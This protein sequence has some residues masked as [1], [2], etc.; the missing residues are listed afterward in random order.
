VRR[1]LITGGSGYL[2]AW[3]RPAAAA[4]GWEVHSTYRAQPG[5]A[6]LD[7]QHALD[8][9]QA[10]A[11]ARLVGELQ[12]DAIL[13]T[14]CSN[15]DNANIAAIT[16]AARHLA[17]AAQQLG[18]RLV[19]VSTDLV[20]DGEHAPYS[21]TSPLAPKGAYGAAKAA[22]EAIVTAQCPSA[23]IVRPSLIWSLEP[24]DRQTTW[25]VDNM[26]RGERVTLFTD[27]VRCPVHRDDL[28]AALLE[29]AER[30][31]LNGPFNMGG[32]Q[33]LNR[34]DFGLK[35]LRALGLPRESNVLP[36]ALGLP[37][38]SNVLPG[39]VAESGLERARNL[40][41]QCTRAAQMLNTPLRGVDESLARRRS[42]QPR[43]CEG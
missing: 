32:P 22:A 31:E 1:L 5:L 4:R 13:H 39:T 7:R 24:L 18:A 6:G 26:R 40:T 16:P 3:L 30:P 29:L 23:A 28:S 25:L 37:R 27:E 43:Y 36:R 9:T 38:E 10:E 11:V 42:H 35:L 14:A 21:D 41:V 2:G 34:W 8:L 19:H 33:A 12:P 15:R 17:C 20:F